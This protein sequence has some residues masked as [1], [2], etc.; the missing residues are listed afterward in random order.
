MLSYKSIKI[1]KILK[2]IILWTPVINILAVFAANTTEEDGLSGFHFGYI[3]SFLLTIVSF[4]VLFNARGK[5]NFIAINYTLLFVML[6][7]SF[8][9]S[10]MLQSLLVF[11]KFLIASC[12]FF[13]GFYAI[14]SIK[15]YKTLLLSTY[16]T[17]ILIVV[18]V[19]LSNIF[20]FGF[21]NYSESNIKFGF[22]GVNLV[23]PL[24]IA[25]I[26]SP[27]TF[28]IYPKRKNQLYV[29]LIILISLA[30]IMLGLKRG[31]VL[32]V[33]LGFVTLIYFT[34]FK[35]KY[36][37]FIPIIVILS[38][39][40]IVYYGEYFIIS[41]QNR[42][43]STR[44]GG[45]VGALDGDQDDTEGR[46]LEINWVLGRFQD[47]DIGTKLIGRDPFLA[48]E[49]ALG[50]QGYKRMNHV[51]LSSILDS[52][53]LIGFI[54]FILWYG[55]IIRYVFK[56][57]QKLKNRYDKEII[58]VCL[59]LIAVHV[60]QS[61]SGTITGI[62]VRGL[63]LLHLGAL[64]SLVISRNIVQ[65]NTEFNLF[66]SERKILKQSFTKKPNR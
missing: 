18:Y 46:V 49:N 58:A 22:V 4:V 11:N 8:L 57:K 25:I 61:I 48:R 27:I 10:N 50:F 39:P 12:L 24:S 44:G 29:V 32:A 13:A 5:K 36:F 9:S 6:L 2:F 28:L 43:E 20:G 34:P 59:A 66:P 23:K 14:K 30:L 37:S 60:A 38:I 16:I 35:R 19:L 53:G 40:V 21:S 64:I 63:I 17:V 3:R 54:L 51:D 33:I 31:T 55:L 26:L 7:L 56:L 65:N 42:M 41:L 1:N 47:A 15:D 62:E 52:F 45:L